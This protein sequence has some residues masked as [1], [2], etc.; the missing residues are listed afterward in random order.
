MNHVRRIPNPDTSDFR[1]WCRP[2]EL[3]RSS[4]LR[5]ALIGVRRGDHVPACR[6]TSHLPPDTTVLCS[7]VLCGSHSG[8]NHGVE[9]DHRAGDGGAGCDDRHSHVVAAAE[10]AQTA[11]A[12]PRHTEDARDL[13][14]KQRRPKVRDDEVLFFWL[15]RDLTNTAQIWCRTS[16]D[17]LPAEVKSPPVTSPARNFRCGGLIA[18]ALRSVTS[19]GKT[20]PALVSQATFGRQFIRESDTGSGN[21]QKSWLSLRHVREARQM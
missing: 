7:F 15:Y 1:T 3:G 19:G 18:T 13:G 21:L 9:P 12:A 17:S 4:D 2:S 8:G 14:C 10:V 16:E 11:G 5:L 6:L 20:L